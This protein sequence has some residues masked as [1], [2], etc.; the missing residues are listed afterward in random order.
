[1]G[2]HWDLIFKIIVIGNS[3][4]G[5]TSLVHRFVDDNFSSEFQSTI[6]VDFKIHMMTVDGQVVK[7]QLWD[8]AGQERFQGITKS[9]YRGANGI[10][11]C[12]D[13]SSRASFE[14]VDELWMRLVRENALPNTPSILAGCKCDLDTVR[15][16]SQDE[17]M[18]YAKQHGMGYIQTSAKESVNVDKAFEFIVR[19]A[20]HL[21]RAKY[22]EKVAN[23]AGGAQA[24]SATGSTFSLTAQPHDRRPEKKRCCGSP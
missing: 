15:Q 20:L 19:S 14:A 2:D 4:V 13:V 6:G 17:A 21:A 16:V 18:Q 11:V 1:M 23:G 7:L 8:T 3:G 24:T 10:L 9:F 22:H 12:F 5:K